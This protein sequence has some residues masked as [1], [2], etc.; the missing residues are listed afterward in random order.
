MSTYH[1]PLAEMQFVLNDLAG[2][3]Q[4]ASLPGF[5]DATP[6]TVTAV[7]EEAARFAT[8]VLDPLNATGDRE[9]SKLLADG[10]VKT[11][12]GFKPA[13]RQ[14]AENGWN[15]LTKPRSTAARICRNSSLRQSRRC[16]MRRTWRST[17]VRC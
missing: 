17:C 14:F 4:V 16:G 8:E 11:P 5:E 10:T 2:L 1:A 6:D 12:A 3:S 9:G 15:G 7:L 13:Y